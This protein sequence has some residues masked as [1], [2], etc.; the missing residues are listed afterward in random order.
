M[1]KYI[2]FSVILIICL[3]ILGCKKSTIKT[4]D[5][6][7]KIEELRRAAKKKAG[8]ERRKGK[9]WNRIYKNYKSL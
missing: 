2:A 1:K 8:K 9:V 5:T 4:V 7:K 3:S 6:S